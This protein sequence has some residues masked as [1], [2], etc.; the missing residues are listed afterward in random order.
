MTR[1]CRTARHARSS[2][3]CGALGPRLPRAWG[4]AA[5]SISSP[6]SDVGGRRADVGQGLPGIAQTIPAHRVCERPRGS[7]GARR[8]AA[9][10]RGER[11]RAHL[12]LRAPGRLAAG[13]A[14][15]DR[16]SDARCAAFEPGSDQQ[17]RGRPCGVS[18]DGLRAALPRR[19]RLRRDPFG[20]RTD[21]R[22]AGHRVRGALPFL[23]RAGV[24]GRSG[25]RHRDDRRQG[26]PHAASPCASELGR[27]RAHCRS[28][29][30]WDRVARHE[31]HH[32]RRTLHARAPR[33]AGP[34]HD[35][36]RQRLCRV[37]RRANRRVR[38]DPDRPPGRPAGRGGG[39]VQWS[40]RTVNGG[41]ALRGRLRAV[42][43]GVFSRESGGSRRPSPTRMR[44][45]IVIPAS[46]PAPGSA[47]C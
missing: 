22:G 13:D 17:A 30:R 14:G 33:H 8:T 42:G 38:A 16:Q 18:A 31:G 21:G 37:L 39:E 25:R 10:P 7:V 6:C 45:I 2:L 44:P 40:L 35:R 15:R 47:I 3:D 23:S 29:S 28:T 11:A 43:A 46:P 41:G 5:T 1:A 26:R 20:H 19:R 9:H 36:G 27:L 32:Y 34:P 4:R 24:G 12:R